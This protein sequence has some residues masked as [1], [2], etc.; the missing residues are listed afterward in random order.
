MCSKIRLARATH[1][2]SD[3]LHSVNSQECRTICNV[4]FSMFHLTKLPFNEPLRLGKCTDHDH[5]RRILRRFSAGLIFVRASLIHNVHIVRYISRVNQWYNADRH[6]RS[7]PRDFIHAGT[8]AASW[9]RTS[10]RA[11][12]HA[13]STYTPV[14]AR[15]RG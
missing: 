6:D 3:R 11:R 8:K 7:L 10:T 4:S 5:V 9:I 13:H 1:G 12:I 15:F 2:R 14:N